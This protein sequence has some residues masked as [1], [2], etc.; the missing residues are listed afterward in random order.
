M[1]FVFDLNRVLTKKDS[2]YLIGKH[3][4]LKSKI[5]QLSTNSNKGNTPF[6]ES[7][8]K[9]VNILKNIPVTEIANL[10]EKSLL[11]KELL[12][13]IQNNREKCIILTEGLDCWYEQ[14]LKKTLCEYHCSKAKIINNKVVS[15]S[16]YLKKEK[17]VSEIQS[18]GNKVVYI[19]YGHSD[20]EA[21]R[22]S[23]I[24]IAVGFNFQPSN[25]I[26]PYSDY[27]IFN[28]K[29][30]CRQLNQLL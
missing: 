9:Q 8:I 15:V 25:S 26:L 21:M 12:L 16:S 2:M 7:L 29:T 18:E 5:L 23:D 19:G 1:K 14:L 30:L 4:D 6:I 17:I 11:R 22:I 27:L 24:A 10:L 3:F 28:E 20:F 13:F